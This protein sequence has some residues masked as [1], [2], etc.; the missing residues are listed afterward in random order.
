MK[1]Y[2]LALFDMDQGELLLESSGDD[3][4]GDDISGSPR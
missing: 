4:M 2:K 1:Q 3:G